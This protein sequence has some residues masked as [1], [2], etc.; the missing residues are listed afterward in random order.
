M[1]TLRDIRRRIASVRNTQQITRA[2]KMVAG[3]KLRRAQQLLAAVRPYAHDITALVRCL[4]AELDYRDLPLI[5]PPDPAAPQALILFTADRGLCGSFNTNLLRA[6]RSRLAELKAQGRRVFLVTVGRKG[7]RFF[8]RLYRRRREEAVEH[9]DWP[10]L[11][12]TACMSGFLRLAGRLEKDVA[13]GRLSSVRVLFSLF[14]SVVKQEPTER[15]LVPIGEEELTAAGTAEE[16]GEETPQPLL[17]PDAATVAREV[18]RRY[19]A[20]GLYRALVENWASE[21]GARMTAMDA[22]TNNAEELIE[23]LTLDYNKARQAA[24]TREI[25]DITGGAEA[26]KEA[27]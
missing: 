18:F 7:A 3:A 11:Y 26:L 15:V 14:H 17:E 21:M 22:A 23:T 12:E 16:H 10:G 19:L 4:L 9:E 20:V 24:I 27:M 13:E 1:P 2:M 25:V 6:A 8:Q 5:Q